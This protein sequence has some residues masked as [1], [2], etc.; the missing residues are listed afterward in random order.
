MEVRVMVV[1]L[2]V[3]G[4]ILLFLFYVIHQVK[5]K[6]FRLSAEVWKLARFN[7]EADAASDTKPPPD[8]PPDSEPKGHSAE[9]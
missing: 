9:E 4:G 3:I 6:R 8:L 5:P 7:V 2:F 1:C